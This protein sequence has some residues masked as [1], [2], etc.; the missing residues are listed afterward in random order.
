[1]RQVRWE[2]EQ[3]NDIIIGDFNENYYNQTLKVEM[4]FE[5]SILYCDFEFLLKCDE[6]VFVNI[7]RLLQLLVSPQMPKR[8]L[9][10][11]Y[12]NIDGRVERDGKHRINE[13]VREYLKDK[14]IGRYF[15][16]YM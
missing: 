4:G 9:F 14:R 12:V 1:M 10:T 11:G 16:I 2:S 5:W 3:Y 13:S 15:N 7:P 6:D 8:K